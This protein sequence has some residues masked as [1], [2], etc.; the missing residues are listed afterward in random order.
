M[1]SLMQSQWP[2]L[3]RGLYL[4]SFFVATY[5][6]MQGGTKPVVTLCVSPREYVS[7]SGRQAFIQGPASRYTTLTASRFAWV[8]VE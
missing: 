3:D 7:L 6:E 4:P 5:L 1:K 2:R 8:S